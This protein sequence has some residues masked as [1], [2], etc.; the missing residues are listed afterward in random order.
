MNDGIFDVRRNYPRE[1]LS[2]V[3]SGSVVIEPKLGDFILLHIAELDMRKFL[4]ELTPMVGV[5]AEHCRSEVLVALSEV[6]RALYIL[7]YAGVGRVKAHDARAERL[8]EHALQYAVFEAAD[9]ICLATSRINSLPPVDATF[10]ACRLASLQILEE[11]RIQL[12]S[13]ALRL[14]FKVRPVGRDAVTSLLRQ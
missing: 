6:A 9:A 10:I 13:L 14:G 12:D 1:F 7:R 4:R 2:F 3:R 8:A 5:L 11:C